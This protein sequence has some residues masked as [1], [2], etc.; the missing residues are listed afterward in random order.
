MNVNALTQGGARSETVRLPGTLPLKSGAVLSDLKARVSFYGNA[1]GRTFLV[2]HGFSSSSYVHEWWPEVFACFDLARDQ[3]MAVN[4][5]GS[6]H[7]ST[8]PEQR[9][10]ELGRAY[11]ADFPEISIDDQARFTLLTLA[12]L[13]ITHLAGVIGCSMGG[14]QAL[15]LLEIAPSLADRWVV[16]AACE[17]PVLAKVINALE[18]RIL[19]DGHYSAKALEQARMLLRIHCASVDGVEGLEKKLAARATDVLSYLREDGERFAERFCPHS[20]ERLIAAMNEFRIEPAG[21]AG[22]LAPHQTVHFIGL[23]NDY[24]TPAGAIEQLAAA[25]R[26]YHPRVT[27]ELLETT[28]GHESWLIDAPAFCETVKRHV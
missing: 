20:Y 2:C 17:L 3:V 7:G 15:K 6:C 10:P 4:V 13:G 27:Y 21:L 18:I 23:T 16:G 22:R 8:G 25:L 24:F 26:A 5:L 1:A 9:S 11:G 19:R 14:Q 12:T 28:F